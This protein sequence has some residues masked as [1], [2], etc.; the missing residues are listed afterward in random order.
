MIDVIGTDAGAPASLPPMH[1]HLVQNADLVAAPKRLL[2]QLVDWLGSRADDQQRLVSDDPIALSDALAPLAPT[3]RIVV[4]AS[5]DPLWFGIGR[6]LIERL[7]SERLRFHPAPSS[8]QLAF[9]RLG[10]PWQ[11]AEW[12][13]LHGRDPSPLAQRLQKRPAALAV[14]T[15]PGRGGVEEVRAILRG[16]GLES[17]YSLWLCE[18]LGHHDERV[19][20]LEANQ[21]CPDDLHPLHLVVLLAQ[22]PAA[23]AAEALPLFGI[24]DGDYL[25][26]DDRPGLM[27]KREVRIQLLADLELPEQ[28]VLWDLGAGT[29]S[30]GLEALRLRPQLQLMAIERRSGGGALIQANAQRLGVAPASVLEGDARTLLPQLPDPDRVLV[31]GGGR[32]RATLLKAVIDRLRPGGVVV[33]PLATLE[34]LAELRPVLE[35]AGLQLQISQQ[36]AW[37][38]QPLAEGTR[39]APMNPVLILKGTNARP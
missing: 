20:C 10:K 36:Q 29:G 28:G 30:V 2:P 22:P 33:I 15:D 1:Q 19:Q 34:A 27:T 14:L 37:R 17:S 4:L 25:Q 12:I 7:G 8:M 6:V 26:H 18:A 38:G 16:S 32:Q 3:L 23:S 35:Q 13:S 24:A 5:G 31:G 11:E 9:A 39:L 21:P